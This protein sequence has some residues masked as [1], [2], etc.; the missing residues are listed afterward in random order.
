MKMIL[1]MTL[2]NFGAPWDHMPGPNAYVCRAVCEGLVTIDPD[3]NTGCVLGD[4][5]ETDA[6]AMTY[7]FTLREGVKFQDGTDFN[8]EAVKWNLEKGKSAGVGALQNMASV[9]SRRC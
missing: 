8:A 6:A 2:G 7:T 4:R 9:R 1:G 3:G 5:V